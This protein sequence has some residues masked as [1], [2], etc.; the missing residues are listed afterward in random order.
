MAALHL[1]QGPQLLY[2]EPYSIDTVHVGAHTRT[3]THTH[4]ILLYHTL[5]LLYSALL[6][7]TLLYY[8]GKNNWENRNL[9]F[10]C[11]LPQH[12]DCCPRLM[13]CSKFKVQTPVLGHEQNRR[14]ITVD[15]QK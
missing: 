12:S 15:S 13:A 1:I 3:H 14:L 8:T 5:V 10:Y 9:Y 11:T 6:Y 2:T 4:S 7:S